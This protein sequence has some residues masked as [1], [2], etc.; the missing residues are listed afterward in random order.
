MSKQLLIHFKVSFF[1]W[2]GF[3]SLSYAKS[4]KTYFSGY[5]DY[6]YIARHS[7][8]SLINIPYRMGSFSI[9]RENSNILLNTTFALEYHVR[10]DS[11]FLST[12]DP[13]DFILDMRELYLTYKSDSYEFHIGKQIHSWGSVDENSPVDNASSLDYYYMFFGGTERKMATLSGSLDYYIG[14]I[15]INTVFY[16]H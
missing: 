12:S 11:Y 10:E 4:P 1:A 14:N 8:Q 6:T 5:V 2:I 13:Q 7:D 16:L 9:E 3:L 15:K